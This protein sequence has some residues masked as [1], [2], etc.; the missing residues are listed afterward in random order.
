MATAV[1]AAVAAGA[2]AVP[3][4]A[5][6]P[7]RAGTLPVTA[8]TAAAAPAAPAGAGAPQ[9]DLFGT[10]EPL[11]LLRSRL[12]AAAQAY[13]EQHLHTSAASLR[14]A[15][16]A[17]MGAAALLGE[18][19]AQG[20]ALDALLQ[21]LEE[22]RSEGEQE[23]AARVQAA[24]ADA[25]AARVEA[26]ASAAEAAALRAAAEE[27]AAAVSDV[28][29]GRAAAEAMAVALLEGAPGASAFGLGIAGLD[30]SLPATAAVCAADSL[31]AMAAA[32]SSGA[33]AAVG[34][35]QPQPAGGAPGG[36]AGAMVEAERQGLAISRLRSQ[37]L[38]VQ[39]W[40]L[41]LVL[42]RWHQPNDLG[43]RA[44]AAYATQWLAALRDWY[45]AAAA[46]VA[47]AA[48]AAA[49]GPAP[50]LEVRVETAA[51]AEGA[52]G[53]GDGPAAAGKGDGCRTLRLH[54]ADTVPAFVGLEAVL[55]ALLACIALL[56]GDLRYWGDAKG[57]QGRT[58]AAA[59]L[60][61]A[62]PPQ[63]QPG[64]KPAKG[65]AA[66]ASAAP[67]AS[68]SDGDIAGWVGVVASKAPFGM[69]VL[70]R[71]IR[72]TLL[73]VQAVEALSAAAE[74]ARAARRT[75]RDASRWRLASTL[76]AAVAVDVA[77]G[78][79]FH[80]GGSTAVGSRPGASL[81]SLSAEQRLRESVAAL[82]LL[83]AALRLLFPSPAPK[84]GCE[85][86]VPSEAQ[87]A[88]LVSAAEAALLHHER[89]AAAEADAAALCA[90]QG[91]A[92]AFPR[93]GPSGG[94]HPLQSAALLAAARE[95]PATTAAATPSSPSSAAASLTAAAGEASAAAG[96]TPA[97]AADP[98][99][100]PDDLR[101]HLQ[102]SDRLRCSGERG[103]APALAPGK[104]KGAGK[105]G[106]EGDRAGSAHKVFVG[107]DLRVRALLAAWS[108]EHL[109]GSLVY[110]AVRAQGAALA[111]GGSGPHGDCRDVG[112]VLLLVRATEGGLQRAAAACGYRLQLVNE[113]ALEAVPAAAAPG[114]HRTLT[115]HD[116][117]LREVAAR[118]AVAAAALRTRL[119]LGRDAVLPSDAA[120][121]AFGPLTREVNGG[122]WKAAK[123]A[124]LAVPRPP[125]WDA[126]YAAPY[127]AFTAAP[128][129][130]MLWR[131]RGPLRPDAA[132][133]RHAWQ[134][135]DSSAAKGSL[136]HTGSLCAASRTPMLAAARGN[137][138]VLPAG[139]AGAPDLP[140]LLQAAAAAAPHYGVQ[141]MPS[142]TP[143]AAAAAGAAAAESKTGGKAG[144]KGKG[145]KGKGKAQVA[146]A[147]G[148]AYR[149]LLGLPG[150]GKVA[151]AI[152]TAV[153]QQEAAIAAVACDTPF[154]P[155]DVARL[156]HRLLLEAPWVDGQ[157][158]SRDYASARPLLLAGNPV[159]PA[160][161]LAAPFAAISGA[162]DVP[163]PSATHELVQG[164]H[165]DLALCTLG[166]EL[167]L[168]HDPEALLSLQE[169]ADAAA[170]SLGAYVGGSGVSGAAS[171]W[172]VLLSGVRQYAGEG[173]AATLS[174][175]REFRRHLLLLGALMLLARFAVLMQAVGASGQ[176]AGAATGGPQAGYRLAEYVWA[177]LL[178]TF[179]AAAVHAGRAQTRAWLALEWGLKPAGPAS[180][181]LAAHPAA[182]IALALELN[183]P[184]AGRPG[185]AAAA[186]SSGVSMA[187][188]ADEG[189]EDD[190]L[191]A[192]GPAFRPFYSPCDRAAHWVGVAAIVLLQLAAF[193]AI[194][195]L[196]LWGQEQDWWFAADVA[197]TRSLLTP[198]LLACLCSAAIWGGQAA[199]LGCRACERRG[200]VRV[201]RVGTGSAGSRPFAAFTPLPAGAGA[202]FQRRLYSPADASHDLARYLAM[203]LLPHLLTV[204]YLALVDLP[205]T[206]GRLL[207]GG[208]PLQAASFQLIALNAAH[209][210]WD[211]LA[212]QVPGCCR[213][214]RRG[215]CSTPCAPCTPCRPSLARTHWAAYF[216][217]WA[218]PAAA[219]GPGGP[220][221]GPSVSP[222]HAAPDA[223]VSS[224]ATAHS[225]RPYNG[226]DG[227]GPWGTPSLSGLP[228]AVRCLTA[229]AAVRDGSLAPA[230]AA[231]GEAPAAR[232]PVVVAATAGVSE[233]AAAAADPRA[234]LVAAL[235]PALEG[236][237][238]QAGSAAGLQ[239]ACLL[240]EAAER[241]AEARAAA[242]MA[243]QARCALLQV[244]GHWWCMAAPGAA[245][246][247]AGAA[248]LR[249]LQPEPPAVPVLGL[250]PK[251]PVTAAGEDDDEDDDEGEEEGDEKEAG[252]SA[253]AGVLRPGLRGGSGKGVKGRKRVG[254][255]VA[256][257]ASPV[258]SGTAAVAGSGA[259]SGADPSDGEAKGAP[260]PP[261]SAPAGR[262][263]GTGKAKGLPSGA[264]FAATPLAGQFSAKATR[265][266][267]LANESVELLPAQAEAQA[268][269]LPGAV[270]ASRD[271]PSLVAVLEAEEGAAAGAGPTAAAPRVRKLVKKGTAAGAKKAAAAAADAGPQAAPEGLKRR[272]GAAAATAPRPLGA[273]ALSA[274][275]FGHLLPARDQPD[276]RAVLALGTGGGAPGA[277][278]DAAAVEAYD[279]S[280]RRQLQAQ[281]GDVN[282]FPPALLFAAHSPALPLQPASPSAEVDAAVSTLFI[283]ANVLAGAV[284]NPW[285]VLLLLPV[286]CLSVDSYASQLLTSSRRAYP[287][288]LHVD[289]WARCAVPLEAL[290]ALWT[291]VVIARNPVTAILPFAW[292]ADPFD[293][294][295][296]AIA[297]V[298]LLALWGAVRLALAAC[299]A[300]GGCV[301][302]RCLCRGRADLEG[303]RA[304][305]QQVEARMS[306]QGGWAGSPLHRQQA[307]ALAPSVSTVVHTLSLAPQAR[308]AR[309]ALEAVVGALG[310]TGTT[311]PQ[312]AAH[313]RR[314]S[315][316]GGAVA[317]PSTSTTGATLVKMPSMRRTGAAE[318]AAATANP[319]AVSGPTPTAV[320][321]AAPRPPKSKRGVTIAAV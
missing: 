78:P 289:W 21:T 52:P 46:K 104:G 160:A 221:P 295:R 28:S 130:A 64:A 133:L 206:G 92:A 306:L 182:G 154:Q 308:A 74:G 7:S 178:L 314:P 103:L 253:A 277:L 269:A 99:A 214:T 185:A 320:S 57:G 116:S 40:T 188:G 297:V 296:F 25:A 176:E 211:T 244:Y 147:V 142:L 311:P 266:I 272:A 196:V 95:G 232:G 259:G 8:A 18:A 148:E 236:T 118:D 189:A 97:A 93:A 146:V 230:L 115:E 242:G 218:Q 288:R 24:L 216:V 79:G 143:A 119:L 223:A 278:A 167:V 137:A 32:R 113:P 205:A 315:A 120:A 180:K 281:L 317:P 6:A 265:A 123:A 161:A 190:L 34:A 302:L 245:D 101:R 258:A 86:V 89:A 260:L 220:A 217:R 37:A 191:L 249:K 316:A 263:L 58:D 257:A 14:E 134:V 219:R 149:D 117:G 187:G 90:E 75:L 131:R 195:F 286:A 170:T 255:A 299:A 261:P 202:A 227:R 276:E 267:G 268:D 225:G 262:R 107:C 181:A 241:L 292:A 305:L 264:T 243:A 87:R 61:F 59:T 12:H 229:A 27:Q 310:R 70:E 66:A 138:S 165:A 41:A 140:A 194:C 208:D 239:A 177:L 171:Q 49:A 141:P 270:P 319:L 72:L 173:A 300:R 155:K 153:A 100:L 126:P 199:F 252:A 11:A 274:Q 212:L 198:V 247:A 318:V 88:L 26:A 238:A 36:A 124:A 193:A 290:A 38:A 231:A 235:L 293:A 122:G 94:L 102:A 204:G 285:S 1:A 275:L 273:L 76:P 203:R 108:L 29:A 47:A 233:E 83:L 110:R 3:D 312:S 175:L 85:P 132:L 183:P 65:A 313:S 129:A 163:R 254:L 284:L 77:S 144:G 228:G 168:L 63:P 271:R 20:A 197:G 224:A 234:A 9:A 106:A 200:G 158:P 91:G 5:G 287:A 13:S 298:G 291:L 294:P 152:E 309:K 162:P 17:L 73:R 53:G 31:A 215:A 84:A 172:D 222:L 51:A 301:P 16:G 174:Q 42:R 114:G 209:L 68:L 71:R 4:D 159:L 125:A 307:E 15:E 127:A 169:A 121:S 192:S 282:A 256:V 111:M 50:D 280:E 67:A 112:D 250:G 184:P 81:A 164:P 251:P 23:A 246:A 22:G 226:P 248:P 128:E 179:G 207:Y 304:Y 80:P 105:G 109:R 35:A 69:A 139:T 201:G 157:P 135:P 166:P 237:P 45:W 30:R 62:M 303:L 55:P 82:P 321:G 240:E 213:R 39:P 96:S 136:S 2:P 186:Y 60:G 54:A 145:G 48:A 19:D 10:A 283:H 43:A 56:F 151:A 33:A 44:R 279:A 210:L 156:T 98:A 150:S